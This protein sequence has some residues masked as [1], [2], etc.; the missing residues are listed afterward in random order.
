MGTVDNNN[1]NNVLFYVLFLFKKILKNQSSGRTK[2]PG[3][4]RSVGHAV[5][6]LRD[7]WDIIPGS[8]KSIGHTALDL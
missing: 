3:S 6:H 4:V 7:Q 2:C 1:N 5:L 8:L